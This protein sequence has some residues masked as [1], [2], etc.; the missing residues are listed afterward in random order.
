MS[1]MTYFII[2]C[3]TFS[4]LFAFLYTYVMSMQYYIMSKECIKINY[5][6]PSFTAVM[7]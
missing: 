7:N 1:Y 6:I 5:E 4:F 2:H 3:C